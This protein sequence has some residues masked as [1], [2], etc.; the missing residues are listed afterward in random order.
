MKTLLTL[1]AV[2]GAFVF[3][4]SIFV[5]DEGKQA[6]IT[7]FGEPVR[8]A[9]NEAGLYFKIPFFQK[10]HEFEKRIIKWD[11]EPNEI[12]TK[13]KKYIWLDTTARWKID[14]P[15][16]F[17]QRMQNYNRANFVIS[18][19]ING[20]V[21]DFVTKN[22]LLEI[23]RSSDWD[24]KY[25]MSEELKIKEDVNIKVGRDQFSKLVQ[26]NVSRTI[27]D[28]GIELIDVLVKR[29]NY[30]VNVRNTVYDRMISE[31]KRIAARR[32]SE[33]EAEKA[34]ILGDMDKQLKEIQSVA[35]RKT[36]KIRGD[37]DGEAARISGEAYS[38]DAD[39]YAFYMTLENY[40]N[41]IGKNTRLVMDAD[42]P[43]YKYLK[44]IEST[45]K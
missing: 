45:S 26:A 39:F 19:L 18:D 7:Q 10:I 25:T 21:R 38:K 22:V 17:L 23:I 5:I 44:N 20:A 15:L 42:S 30:T 40:K 31:R 34:E 24:E 11:G 16:L 32:R 2:V 29:V 43:L 14:N 27:K 36:Q 41:L 35:F 12:P 3:Y 28:F 1:L 13:D 37:A 4:N 33:G 9:F 8:G 6:I